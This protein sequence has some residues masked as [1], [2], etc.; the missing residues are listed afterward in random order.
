MAEVAATD[1]TA[2]GA[3]WS[4]SKMLADPNFQLLLANMGKAADPEGVGGVIGGAAANMISS[5]AAQGALEKRDAARQQQI[6]QLI[7][8]HAGITPPDK[9]GINSI[10]MTPAGSLAL[11]LNLGEPGISGTPEA[12]AFSNTVSS[13]V[14][15]EPRTQLL[16]GEA[17]KPKPAL[18]PTTT[19][20]AQAAPASTPV[21]QRP[22]APRNVDITELFPFY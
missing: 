10:K 5:K 15:Q 22:G 13:M 14:P 6:K 4:F 11:D 20:P 12:K 8:L 19:V 9:P 7:D 2:A 1:P 18:V 16:T 17:P 3:S 21:A